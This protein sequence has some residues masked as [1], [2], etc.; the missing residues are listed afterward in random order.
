[1]NDNMYN[2]IKRKTRNFNINVSDDDIQNGF[3]KF[4]EKYNETQMNDNDKIN[5]I[6]KII[7]NNCKQSYNKNKKYNTFINNYFYVF[8][9]FLNDEIDNEADEEIF[10]YLR[11]QLELLL[12]NLPTNYIMFFRLYY[13]E[14]NTLDNIATK[15]N[16]K[17]KSSIFTI[18]QEVIKHLKEQTGNSNIKNDLK[19]IKTY[20]KKYYKEIYGK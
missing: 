1:M 10:W 11:S 7:Y 14:N 6:L 5:C 20:T 18:K 4:L 8:N 3:L 17:N 19:K 12:Q 2:Q 13:L 9:T 16:Y 15:L